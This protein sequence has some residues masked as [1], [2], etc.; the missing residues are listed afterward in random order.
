MKT[1]ELNNLMDS[2][3][4]CAKEETHSAVEATAVIRALTNLASLQINSES[5]R[6]GSMIGS[7][8]DLI[9][10]IFGDLEDE[11]KRLLNN[12][13]TCYT[14]LKTLEKETTKAIITEAYDHRESGLEDERWML[15]RIG[16]MTEEFG[17][18][19][20]FMPDKDGYLHVTWGKQCWWGHYKGDKQ[21]GELD[22]EDP[23]FI[24]FTK[25]RNHNN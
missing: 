5:D 24:D 9:H 21:V 15:G 18:P 25:K 1:E 11:E 13:F 19:A 16:H 23:Y 6:L 17:N 2:A 14:M 22:K 8:P 20:I 12:H 3:I 10:E 7:M 4:K